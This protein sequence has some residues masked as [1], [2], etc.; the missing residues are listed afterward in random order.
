M[1]ILFLSRSMK[2]GEN[3]EENEKGCYDSS[4]FCSSLTMIVSV[5]VRKNILRS[6]GV[7]GCR[8]D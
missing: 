2:S 6:C 1:E 5:R 8:D 4:L 7:Y 3:C